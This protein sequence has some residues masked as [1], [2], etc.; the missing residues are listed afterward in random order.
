MTGT[1]PL[2]LAHRGTRKYAPENSIPS[3]IKAVELGVDG[4]E[5]DLLSTA[6]GLPIVCHDDNL[7]KLSNKHLHIHRTNWRDLKDVDIGKLFNPFYAGENIPTLKEA[8]EV[9]AG[10][11]MFINIELKKQPQQNGDF[12]KNVV[13]T[14]DLYKG[15]FRG[16]L[17]SSFS[18]ELLYQAGRAAPQ[19]D[20]GLLL[21]PRAFFFLD[22]LFFGNILVVQWLNIHTSSLGGRIMRH[23]KAKGL[24]V[25]VWTPN[26]VNDIKKALEAG[27]DGIISDEP[28]LVKEVV[29]EHYG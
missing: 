20:R 25:F 24:K 12:V 14:L 21:L 17:L 19:I 29:R 8:L 11:N 27:V 6:D 4:V 16:V 5:F 1:P 10:K 22:A 3:F 15:S 7:H 18:K 9:L 2:I 26:E 23:A 13:E 28:V